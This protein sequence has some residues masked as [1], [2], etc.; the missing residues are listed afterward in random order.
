MSEREATAVSSD[1]SG[2]RD[3]RT[4]WSVVAGHVPVHFYPQGFLV[5]VPYIADSLGLSAVQ[6]GLFETTRMLGGGV[7]SIGGGI[8]TDRFQAL[9]RHFMIVS[10]VLMALGYLMISLVSGYG[11]ILIGLAIGAALGSFWHPP[12]SSVL[13]QRF[14]ERRGYVIALHR[15]SGTAGDTVAPFVVGALIGVVSWQAVVQGSS[16]VTFAFAG[17][18]WMTLGTLSLDRAQR[19]ARGP[20]RGFGAQFGALGGVFKQ[21]ALLLLL[22]VSGLRGVADRG[23]IVFFAFYLKETLGMSPLM[24]GVHF[25]LLTALAI[26]TGPFIGRTSDRIGRKPVI[27]TIMAISAVLVSLIALADGGWVFT[28]LVLL[29]GSVMFSVS[30]LVQAGAMDVAH[31]LNLEGSLMGMYWGVNSLFGGASPLILGAILG[32]MNNDYSVIFWYAAAFYVVGMFVAL[33]LPAAASGKRTA[34]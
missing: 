17:V 34:S 10:L 9:R 12:A 33:A 32:W 11:L 13:S 29:L 31:G 6:A 5:I 3:R 7:A 27:V 18:L 4:L 23:L 14:P 21:R 16:I 30:S 1:A 24:V 26:V 25:G 8:V 2:Q 28:V 22:L 15:S 20:Q 19:K